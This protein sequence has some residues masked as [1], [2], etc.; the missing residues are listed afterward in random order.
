MF[1]LFKLMIQG[2]GYF[3]LCFLT[4]MF[5]TKS[6]MIVL[7]SLWSEAYSGYAVFTCTEA[8]LVLQ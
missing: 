4:C 2:A 6:K 5:I 3:M 8:Y 7:S 1:K